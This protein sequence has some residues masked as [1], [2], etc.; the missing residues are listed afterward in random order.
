MP[1]GGLPYTETSV[2]LRR[3]PLA[4]LHVT[5]LHERELGIKDGILGDFKLLREIGRGG[6]GRVYE[7]EQLSLHRRVAIKTLPLAESV[8]PSKLRRFK[9]EAKVAAQLKHPNIVSVYSVGCEQNIDYYAMEFVEGRNLAEIIRDVRKSNEVASPVA[10]DESDVDSIAE[11]VEYTPPAREIHVLTTSSASGLDQPST[12]ATLSTLGESSDASKTDTDA[13]RKRDG[14]WYSRFVAELGIQVTEALRHAHQLGVVHRDIKPSNLMLNSEGRVLVT[15]FGLARIQSEMDATA[16]GAIVGTLRYC[17]PEQAAGKRSVLDER[18]DIY[19]LG[20]TLYE[21]LTLSPFFEAASRAELVSKVLTENPISPRRKA[22]WIPTDL[23][24]IVLKAIEKDASDRYQSADEFGEDL[25]RFLADLPVQAKRPTPLSYAS[26]WAKRNTGLLIGAAILLLLGAVVGLVSTLLIARAQ[27]RTAEALIDAQK[28][29]ELAEQ[30]TELAEQRTRQLDE[31]VRENQLFLYLSDIKR[32][33]GALHDDDLLRL[34]EILGRFR[35]AEYDELRG[36]EWG[37]LWNHAHSKFEPLQPHPRGSYQVRYS[38]DGKM[39]ASCGADGKVYIYQADAADPHVEIDTG[40]G[41]VN[42]IAFDKQ[43][44][45]IATVGDDG[46]VRVWDVE[47]KEETL[48]IDAHDDLAFGVQFAADGQ[49]LVSCGREANIRIWDVATGEPVAVL[50]GHTR[51]VE[52]ICLLPDGRHLASVSTDETVRIWD[53]QTKTEIET[54]TDH[55]DKVSSIACTPDGHLVTGDIGGT[56]II[57]QPGTWEP[58]SRASYADGVQ[59][60]AAA[61]NGEVVAVG[62]RGGAIHLLPLQQVDEDAPSWKAHEGRVYGL[63]FMPSGSAIVSCGQKGPVRIWHLSECESQ[64]ILT[65]LEK[66]NDIEFVAGGPQLAVATEKGLHLS[67]LSQDGNVQ[68]LQ[69]NVHWHCVSTSPTS[70][71]VAAGT[72]T[73][74]VGAWDAATGRELFRRQ[75]AT[76]PIDDVLVIDDSRVA[77]LSWEHNEGVAI[78]DAHS[79]AP[80]QRLPAPGCESMCISRDSKSL[81]VVMH[82]DFITLWDLASPTSPMELKGHRTTVVEVAF[83]PFARRLYSVSN[84]RT[85]VAWNTSTGLRLWSAVAHASDI[86]SVAVSGDGHTLATVAEK[87]NMIRLWHADSGQELFDIKTR[88]P[89]RSLAMD[90]ADAYLVS[91]GEDGVVEVFHM[92]QDD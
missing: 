2:S 88:A 68:T 3:H 82:G 77:W 31:Q 28:Q 75:V 80:L 26:K 73:G 36:P 42:G 67:D 34:T 25:R 20:V 43:C 35:S 84:D 19:S 37:Y 90:T 74:V 69:S 63:T 29:T 47:T 32:A 8:S 83:S 23:E 85:M 22:P 56:V 86:E 79:G 16:T 39:L 21:L 60:I 65:G 48:T 15:D 87:S 59:S 4:G 45:R 76:I 1:G 61:P 6:M 17:S 62:D 46:T 66:V 50:E 51:A 55:Q 52:A 5:K 71:I 11:T 64:F 13:N 38:G 70:Q 81:A 53:L 7:A 44:R 58:L 40:Q 33:E 27:R 78:I 24:T 18:S 89:S 91:L 12:D 49:Q 41:E 9:V 10:L 54:L 72:A 14:A 30:Q 92:N 57:R